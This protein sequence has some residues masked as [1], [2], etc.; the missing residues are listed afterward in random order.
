MF[1]E[2]SVFSKSNVFLKLRD[3]G[4]TLP[5][6]RGWLET[7]LYFFIFAVIA[8]PLARSSSFLASPVALSVWLPLLATTFFVPALLEELIW[9]VLLVPRPNAKN[10]W[11]FGLVSLIVYVASHPLSAWLFRPTARDVFYTPAFLFLTTLLGLVCLVVYARTKSLWA[12]VVIHW[13]VVAGWLLFGAR[14]L[15]ETSLING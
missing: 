5:T 12:S 6:L 2:N 10:F 3:A 1:S 11:S 9:R 14:E 7:F 8:V 15:L 13:L 4:M